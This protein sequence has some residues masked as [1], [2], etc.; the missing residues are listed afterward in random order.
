M[1]IHITVWFQLGEGTYIA[2]AEFS[3]ADITFFPMLAFLVRTGLNLDT[4]PYLAKYYKLMCERKSVKASWP[5]HWKESEGGK[6]L[7]DL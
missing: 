1:L 4:F 6:H 7:A 2:D 5:P 3:I